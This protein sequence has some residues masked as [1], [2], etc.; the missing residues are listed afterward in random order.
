MDNLLVSNILHRRARSVITVCGLALG[1]A[2]VMLAVGLVDGFLYAQGRRNAAVAADILFAPPAASFGFGFSSSLSA[3]LP[4][5]TADQL[6][7]VQ[8]VAEAVPLYQCLEGA[9]MIDGIDYDSFQR[10]SSVH[11]VEGRPVKTGDEVMIDRT[12]ER[13]LKLKPGSDLEMLGRAFKVV[14]VYEPES[15][16]RFKVPISTIQE[17]NHRPAAG[18]MIL[19]KTAAETSV[20]DV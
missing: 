12:A 11:V 1:V 2:L 17:F 16:Y 19:V 8:G 4:V 14:G 20:E 3:T 9:R 13:A 15:L 6:S 5:E 7:R 18:S 10:V